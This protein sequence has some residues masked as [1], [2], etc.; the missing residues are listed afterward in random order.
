LI[1]SI[2]VP[3]LAR[4]ISGLNLRLNRQSR[5]S[6]L[7]VLGVVLIFIFFFAFFYWSR[8]PVLAGS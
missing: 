6:I 3:G 1:L 5:R 8:A 4:Q 7:Y 2:L